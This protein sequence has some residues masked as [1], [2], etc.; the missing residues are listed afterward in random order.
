[1][2]LHE[3]VGCRTDLDTPRK[4]LLSVLLDKSKLRGYCFASWGTLAECMG[5]GWRAARSGR[6][7]NRDHGRKSVKRLFNKLRAEFPGLLL[8]CPGGMRGN[9]APDTN[10]ISVNL[11]A[12]DGGSSL[13]LASEGGGGFETPTPGGL[14]TPEVGAGKPPPGGVSKPPDQTKGIK[15][16][17]SAGPPQPPDGGGPALMPPAAEEIWGFWCDATAEQRA[18]PA[19]AVQDLVRRRIIQFAIEPS[20]GRRRRIVSAYVEG[21][22]LLLTLEGGAAGPEP[23][24]L[25]EARIPMITF[26]RWVR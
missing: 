22:G 15:P 8:I 5:Y 3:A 2:K 6:A 19:A 1:V 14:S 24:R 18:R 4:V 20:T 17:N 13:S 21:R 10:R 12:L 23:V 9:G 7:P 25:D 16:S 11:S 26:G